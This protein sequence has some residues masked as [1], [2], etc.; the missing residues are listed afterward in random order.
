[1]GRGLRILLAPVRIPETRC[2]PVALLLAGRGMKKKIYSL[3]LTFAIAGLAHALDLPAPAEDATHIKTFQRTWCVDLA[4]DAGATE[5]IQLEMY[6]QSAYWADPEWYVAN[7]GKGTLR[8]RAAV[9]KPC[10]KNVEVVKLYIGADKGDVEGTCT[11]VAIKPGEGDSIKDTL[12]IWK[13]PQCGA[14]ACTKFCIWKHQASRPV[15]YT[16]VRDK[17]RWG[18]GKCVP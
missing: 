16:R 15:N 11:C 13:G 4:D 6:Q 10:A 2:V 5:T 8:S 17:Y 9:E 12:E 14:A 18:G 7:F 1:M 3:I